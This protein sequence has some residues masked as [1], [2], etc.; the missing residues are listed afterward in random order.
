MFFLAQAVHKSFV[1]PS[2]LARVLFLLLNA[3]AE[4]NKVINFKLTDLYFDLVLVS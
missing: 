3:A 4:K 1:C 2:L